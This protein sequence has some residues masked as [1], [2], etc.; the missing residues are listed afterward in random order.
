[1][2][3][4]DCRL[5]GIQGFDAHKAWCE[6]VLESHPGK[7]IAVVLPTQEPGLLYC[8]YSFPYQ[9]SDGHRLKMLQTLGYLQYSWR[10]FADSHGLEVVYACNQDLL[11]V[12]APQGATTGRVQ[13]VSLNETLPAS[14]QS[15]QPVAT[16]QP[17]PRG[18]FFDFI[19]SYA[20]AD[21]KTKLLAQLKPLAKD[22]FIDPSVLPSSRKELRVRLAEELRSRLKSENADQTETVQMLELNQLL[23]RCHP[24]TSTLYWLQAQ[25]YADG[26][27]TEKSVRLTAWI[28]LVH[29]MHETLEASMQLVNLSCNAVESDLG[30]AI[31]GLDENSLTWRSYS[32]DPNYF[33]RNMLFKIA[34]LQE[35][36]RGA[37]GNS[38]TLLR[39]QLEYACWLADSKQHDEAVARLGKVAQLV[40]AD[41]Q[42]ASREIGWRALNRICEVHAR[43]H[44][45]GHRLLSA[46][47]ELES[48]LGTDPG[49]LDPVMWSEFRMR[50]YLW[51]CKALA[52]CDSEAQA[53]VFDEVHAFCDQV[54]NKFMRTAGY[55]CCLA[56]IREL[57]CF[58]A[59][60]HCEHERALQCLINGLDELEPLLQFCPRGE[61]EVVSLEVFP[62]FQMLCLRA[63][64]LCQEL[65]R[66]EQ[67]SVIV[68]RI[69]PA[70]NLVKWKHYSVAVAH[71]DIFPESAEATLHEKIKETITLFSNDREE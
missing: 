56:R 63:A 33:I 50:G 25:L 18:G 4:I 59:L 68:S 62:I 53:Q 70:L 58:V 35:F 32:A 22:D 30:N 64:V 37:T 38:P 43:D 7:R 54:V 47:H 8:H 71:A 36:A 29:G 10:C 5:A 39:L 40:R 3:T 31:I 12:V 44:G 60:Q 45:Q 52:L 19:R 17:M 61:F 26:T 49:D 57:E 24:L 67:S 48:A 11:A 14:V 46:A 9:P 42:R 21:W 13:Y 28:T 15:T 20:K 23:S 1:M 69:P 66:E 55:I 16:V 34:S 41:G 27:E 51:R 65:G 2:K 6:R